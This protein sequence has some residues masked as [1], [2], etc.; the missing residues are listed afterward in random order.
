MLSFINSIVCITINPVDKFYIKQN[1]K[2]L[3]MDSKDNGVNNTTTKD[4]S[5]VFEAV[6]HNLGGLSFFTTKK[7]LNYSTN[8]NQGGL[9]TKDTSKP[10]NN[11]LVIEE[12]DHVK[13]QAYNPKTCATIKDGKMGFAK[14]EANKEGSSY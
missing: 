3:T 14:C 1:K 6:K 7:A 9:Y 12:G 2:Y 11:W 4:T 8:Y 10:N 5:L 13:L